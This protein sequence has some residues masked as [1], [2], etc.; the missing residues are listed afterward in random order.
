VTSKYARHADATLLQAAD[1]VALRI[2]E[3]MG[4][5]RLSSDIV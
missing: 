4:E 3:L 5:A 1:A 2:T